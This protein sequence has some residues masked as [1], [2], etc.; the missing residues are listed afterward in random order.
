MLR[1]REG[2]REGVQMFRGTHSP[3]GS[4]LELATDR[5]EPA[6]SFGLKTRG[7]VVS[8]PKRLPID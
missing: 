5:T 6:L 3:E 7:R 2:G 1:E 4:K 8:K